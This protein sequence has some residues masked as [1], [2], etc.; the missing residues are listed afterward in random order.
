MKWLTNIWNTYKNGLLYHETLEDKDAALD[1]VKQYQK[2]LAKVKK[3]VAKFNEFPDEQKLQEYWHTK[4]PQIEWLHR[5]RK[6]VRLDPRYFLSK[7]LTVPS[8]KHIKEN[9]KRALEALKTVKNKVTYTLKDEKLGEFWKYSYETWKDKKGDCE[10][11]AILMYNIMMNSGVPSWRIRLNCGDVH[12]GI[13]PM[14]KFI[15]AVDIKEVKWFF[16]KVINC[17]ITPKVVLQELKK[18]NTLDN[19]LN[20]KKA[21]FLQTKE[22]ELPDK[23]FVDTLGKLLKID[24][25]FVKDVERLNRYESIIKTKIGQTMLLKIW[26]FYVILVIADIMVKKEILD[27]SKKDTILGLH[28]V[29]K[30]SGHAY[31]TYL[32]EKDNE[33]YVLDWCYWHNPNGT[34]WKNAHKYYTDSDGQKGF[35][36]WGSL[37]PD[38][39][40]GDL[41]KEK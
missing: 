41:P 1:V 17:G 3:V 9:D 8:F 2:E 35:S 40:Y 11:G 24:L 23:L 30:S 32:K 38:F 22:Q 12:S 13:P 5:A 37:N 21:L 33:W 36:I 4:R 10:D 31:I 15:K 20:L 6:G 26:K 19:Q 29:E 28:T 39:I 25:N 14:I 7:D 18:V 16:K 34:L 27:S